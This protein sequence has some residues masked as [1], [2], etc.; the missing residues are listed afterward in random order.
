MGLAQIPRQSLVLQARYVEKPWGRTELPPA[1]AG[2][3][4]RR[5]GEVWFDHGAT[6][7][8][9]LL[10]RYIFTNE[11]LSVQVHPDDE[12]ALL[13]GL[14]RGKNECWY[15]V[16]A[17]AGASVGLGLT[18]PLSPAAM[19]VAAMDGSIDQMMVW[20]PV[21]PG[22][23]FF[24]PAGTIHAIGAGISLLEFQ[25]NADTTY[26]LY[27]YERPRELHL[28]EGVAVARPAYDSERNFRPAGGPLDCVLVSSPHFSLIRVTARGDIA[29]SLRNRR[30][31]VMPLDGTA[32]AD[33]ATASAWDC[34]LAEKGTSLEMSP[35]TVALIGVE[36]PL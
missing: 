18:E 4:G 35:S 34:M 5:I 14:A 32:T 33:G 6:C 9:P 1:F 12:Q 24:V 27:D 16:D 19:R 13:R 11:K 21:A 29:D 31:W 3:G 22:D 23:F 15:I 7:A 17:H 8:L 28:E 36:G 25:Q 30:R 2:A 10:A 26:R 20:R